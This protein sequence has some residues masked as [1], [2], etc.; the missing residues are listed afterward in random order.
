MS[1][2]VERLRARAFDERFHLGLG[3]VRITQADIDEIE[4]LR[5]WQR[6]AVEW[7]EAA[8]QH[9]CSYVIN[10][11]LCGLSTIPCDCGRDALIAEAHHE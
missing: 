8:H 2:I 7:I 3:D 9:D 10:E 5:D 1:D 11:S 4:R 6:R